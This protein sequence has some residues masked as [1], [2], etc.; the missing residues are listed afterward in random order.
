[1]RKDGEEGTSQP[2][3]IEPLTR[4]CLQLGFISTIFVSQFSNCN[5]RLRRPIRSGK[6]LR[7]FL[8]YS[9]REA[10]RRRCK[11]GALPPGACLMVGGW[12][13]WLPFYSTT[14]CLIHPKASYYGH[15]RVPPITKLQLLIGQ[16]RAAAELHLP[17]FLLRRQFIQIKKPQIAFR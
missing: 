13:S 17:H 8:H 2:S 3:R 11:L 4:L 10:A 9:F 12:R 7:V 5:P 1:M 16:C 6:N 14:L 15:T